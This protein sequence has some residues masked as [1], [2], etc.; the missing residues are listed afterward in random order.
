MADQP[1][2]I[3]GSL[4]VAADLAAEQTLVALVEQLAR[5]AELDLPPMAE[6]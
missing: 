3:V 1:Q 2:R 4:L 6:Q 5:P